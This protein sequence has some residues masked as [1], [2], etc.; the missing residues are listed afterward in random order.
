VT[1]QARIT[2]LIQAI[3]L[4]IKSIN[5]S[6]AKPVTTI[7]VDL[8]YPAKTS[9]SFTITGLSGLIANKQV[10]ISQASGPYTAKSNNPDE[11]EMDSLALSGYVMDATSIKVFY[12]SQFP[13]G[14]NFKFNYLIQ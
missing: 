10:V 3:G 14:G 4:D 6:I 13:V 2:A 8:G 7:E 1:L 9:G 5:N 12:I 11:A